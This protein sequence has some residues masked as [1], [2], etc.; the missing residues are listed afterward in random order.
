[1]PAIVPVA[2]GLPAERTTVAPAA[3]G[4]ANPDATALRWGDAS[5][6]AA[7]PLPALSCRTAVSLE[8]SWSCATTCVAASSVAKALSSTTS[9]STSVASPSSR[10][11]STRSSCATF[12]S[13][14]SH[15]ASSLAAGA[16]CA[17]TGSLRSCS[18]ASCS[19]RFANEAVASPLPPAANGTRSGSNS[20]LPNW[21]TTTLPFLRRILCTLRAASRSNTELPVT[22]GWI[23]LRSRAQ[24]NLRQNLPIPVG[25]FGRSAGRADVLDRATAGLPSRPCG[26]LIGRVRLRSRWLDGRGRISSQTPLK[27]RRVL[28]INQG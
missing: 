12:S 24:R 26:G 11:R 4:A 18:C 8:G 5:R 3:I 25:I 17:A 27:R 7:A 15:A 16:V 21:V 20:T 1:M 13:H 19:R 6:S 10:G 9:V 2:A 14:A 22:R 23:V 28:P